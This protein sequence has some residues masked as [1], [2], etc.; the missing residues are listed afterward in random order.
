M[1]LQEHLGQ[2]AGVGAPTLRSEHVIGPCPGN[3]D[4][5]LA[6]KL[7]VRGVEDQARVAG[8]VEH[9]ARR[10][11]VVVARDAVA[12]ED[13]LHL[14]DVVELARPAVPRLELAGRPLHGGR[15]VLGRHRRP[16]ALVAAHASGRLAGPH[17]RAAP[18]RLDHHPPLVQELEIDERVGGHGEVGT[19]VG[20][21]RHGAQ[22]ALVVEVVPGHAGRLGAGAAVPRQPGPEPFFGRFDHAQRLDR[23]PLDPFHGSASIDV[24]HVKS[25]LVLCQ[26]ALRGQRRRRRPR[27]QRH[28]I[29][30][31]QP[32]G[33]QEHFVAEDVDE[34]QPGPLC[35]TDRPRA[36]KVFSGERI[37]VF[38][39]RLDFLE[40]IV[41][42]HPDQPDRRGRPD[43]HHR[44]LAVETPP[45]VDHG[46]RPPGS[47][48]A[49]RKGGHEP[50]GAGDRPG[51]EHRTRAVC[52]VAPVDGR[53]GP[54]GT[55]APHALGV[56]EVAVHVLPAVVQHP[57]VGRQRS[58]ALVQRAVPDLMNVRSVGVHHEQVAHDVPV[59]HAILGL[60]RGSEEDAAVGQVDGVDVG[61]TRA[62]RKLHQVPAVGADLIY[63]I[64]VL[65]VPPHREEDPA[66]VEADVG[67]ASD[68][69][70]CIHQR[71]HLAAAAEIDPLH[72]PAALK[73]RRV[74]LA[75]LEHRGRVVV[76]LPILVAD[77]EQDRPAADQRVSRQ[78][79]A[80]QHGELLFQ[81]GGRLV[82][83]GLLSL[84]LDLF[85]PGQV[86]SP[87]RIPVAESLDQIGDC[88]TKRIGAGQ[89]LCP[90][91]CRR[92]EHQCQG[93]PARP[94]PDGACGS[95]CSRAS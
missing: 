22:D 71:G 5:L 88:R 17:D 77:H 60:P 31:A 59:A 36:K 30:A 75:R 81:P 54:V 2:A 69:P 63:V 94:R 39:L 19:A 42:A 23:A 29:E 89:P 57:A 51:V 43:L 70:G 93:N 7:D 44:R 25:A 80:P 28:G 61:D 76:V 56:A 95:H 87:P 84:T 73:L 53:V 74:D 15:Q 18:H 9:L 79:L 33:V 85:E 1:P 90:S 26:V 24:G 12:I 78:G 65:R 52:A 6:A 72:G 47:V 8:Q 46:Q 48:V 62:E 3:G 38:V 11:A 49:A 50:L 10:L 40:R 27:G 20:L 41:V 82:A 92:R 16:A 34:P 21:D 14:G 91:G 86:L 68:S 67:V 32:L 83:L 55:H 58:V 13:R 66:A 45:P 35:F 64:V 4:E 37:R